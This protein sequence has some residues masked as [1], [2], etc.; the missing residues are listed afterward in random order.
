MLKKTFLKIS[1]ILLCAPLAI[2][3]EKEPFIPANEY[4]N[5][6]EGVG[7][8]GFAGVL[9]SDT[10][11][12][13]HVSGKIWRGNT[14]VSPAK[15]V[16]AE[17]A[18][19]C[20]SYEPGDGIT[21]SGTDYGASE[22]MKPEKALGKPTTGDTS[23]VV[24]LGEGGKITLSFDRPIRDGDGYDFAIFE[25]SLNDTFIE[26]AFVEVSSDGVHFVRFPNFYLGSSP[27][28]S[29]SDSGG[30][31]NDAT[32]IYNLGSKYRIGF[33]NGYDLA[34]L[35]QAHEYILKHGASLSSAPDASCIFT[36]QY[37]ADFLENYAY[38][39]LQSVKY[40]RLI[41]IVGDGSTKD[42]SG[43]V[44]YDAYP[45]H[46]TSGFD[47]SG[48]G[49]INAAAT[50]PL[51]ESWAEAN[52]TAFSEAD[53]LPEAAP[54]GDGIT[55]LERYAFDFPADRPYSYSESG[56]FYSTAKADGT[57]VFVYCVRSG[58]EDVS[59]KV[60]WSGDLISWSEDGL[61][62]E[63]L[64]DDGARK[65]ISCAGTFGKNIFFRVKL[66]GD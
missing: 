3:Q 5:L 58:M 37:C 63:I 47:L 45:T 50:Q 38:L 55:N 65:I 43:T 6:M 53:R 40:V 31:V 34:E 18:S 46:G 44:I 56:Y 21:G 12:A 4:Y 8:V 57:A 22:W 54:F 9:G 60:E 20:V 36:E 33:G 61:S 1:L 11:A 66:V 52:L 28:G 62:S 10:N 19:K 51:Y 41:D 14:L 29:D 42:S 13:I 16:F 24:V 32:L 27:V 2:A 59:V 49:A 7:I 25:N 35:K 15:Y 48:I 26:L 23:D 17:W 39:D 64:S 30:G